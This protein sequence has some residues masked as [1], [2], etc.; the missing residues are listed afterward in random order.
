MADEQRLNV[1]LTR[2][3]YALFVVGNFSELRRDKTWREMAENAK[4][5]KRFVYVKPKP[6]RNQ[7]FKY[8]QSVGD[9]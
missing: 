5:R 3:R 9:S 1:A 4:E 2:A 7:F 6:N 8:L